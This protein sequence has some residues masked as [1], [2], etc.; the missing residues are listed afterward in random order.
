MSEKVDALNR[1]DFISKLEKLVDLISEN[2][3]G[4]CFG[5]DG[6]WGSGKSFILEKFENRIKDV[7]LEETADNKYFVFHYDCW[8]YDYYDEP[9]IAIISAML[10]ETDKELSVLSGEVKE[11]MRLAWETTKETLKAIA[12]AICK[13][14]LGIDYVEIA[15]DVLKKQDEEVD[16]EFDSLYGFKRALEAARDGI[17]KIAENKTVIIVVD[18]LDRCLPTYSIKVLERLHHIFNELNNVIVIVSMDK[19]QLAH[20]IQG[21]YGD[22]E[23]DTYLRKF[24]S[25][26]MDLDNGAVNSYK[27]KYPSYFSMFDI[28]ETEG[29]K[30]EKLFSD[31]L[32]GIDMRTQERIFR[33]AEIIHTIIKD[34]KE[35]DSS[36]IALEILFIT[37]ALRAKTRNLAWLA[38]IRIGFNTDI[39]KRIGREYYNMLVEYGKEGMTNPTRDGG[40]VINN[41]MIGRTLFWLSGM[42]Y[43][44]KDG[45]CGKLYY[46]NVVDTRK[47]IDFACRFKDMVDII[48]TD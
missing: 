20:S 46:N 11:G 30:L 31:I 23:V 7:V 16:K 36:I 6:A 22:I 39:E 32:H 47:N 35:L 28:M 37:V 18:E 19:K 2:G 9:A 38:E 12:G 15:S 25:F 43:E 40:Y 4:C 1:E 13:N 45:K 24:I 5:I 48:D 10:D 26:K 44:F 14:K 34:E 41:S 42:F 29:E 27:E 21:I 17:Q 33:K 8:K 3:Q